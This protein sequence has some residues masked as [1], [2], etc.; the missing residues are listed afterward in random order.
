MLAAFSTLLI[1]IAVMFS[2][3]LSTMFTAV[4]V[5]AAANLGMGGPAVEILACGL[6]FDAFLLAVLQIRGSSWTKFL[7]V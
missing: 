7:P 4:A 1:S 3:F 6:E 5:F 2:S